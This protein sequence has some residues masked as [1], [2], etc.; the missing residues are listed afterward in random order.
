MKKSI[1]SSK[2]N[3][4][5]LTKQDRRLYNSNNTANKTDCNLTEQIME[6]VEVINKKR[7][8]Q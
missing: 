1:L 7:I 4:Q 8:N 3:V 2:E 6:F 5:I